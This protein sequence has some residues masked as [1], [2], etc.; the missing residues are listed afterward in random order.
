MKKSFGIIT[1]VSMWGIAVWAIAQPEKTTLHLAIIGGAALV[2]FIHLIEASF[3]FW[4][5]KM[6]PHLSA[7]NIG[8]T[9]LCGVYH[10]MPLYKAK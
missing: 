4:H 3:F 10:F 2:F 1:S 6:K 9:L 5:P 8:M 7:Y